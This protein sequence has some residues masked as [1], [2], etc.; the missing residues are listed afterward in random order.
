MDSFMV[1]LVTGAVMFVMTVIW[2]VYNI[3]GGGARE[4]WAGQGG[5]QFSA[6][7]PFYRILT[8]PYPPPILT[9]A[10]IS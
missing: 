4:I 5:P 8:P 3:R 10:S 9:A 1:G 6:F 2:W 7:R